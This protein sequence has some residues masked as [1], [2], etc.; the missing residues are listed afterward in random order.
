MRRA[1]TERA[2]LSSPEAET[3]PDARPPTLSG[4]PG[5]AHD[6]ASL[7][8]LALWLGVVAFGGGFAVAQRIKRTVVDQRRWLD[9]A[10]FV[11]IFSV[12]SALPGTTS[13]NVLTMVGLRL[14]GVRAALLVVA[15]F[16]APSIA[17][18]IVFGMTY[19]HVRSVSMVSSLLDG[20]SAATVGVI[21]A[22]AID[23]RAMALRGRLGWLLAVFA[24]VALA[25]RAL[26]LLEVV[27]LSGL[28][29]AFALR[30]KR[31]L[32]TAPPE[33]APT[34][35]DASTSKAADPVSGADDPFPPT[36]LRGIY[37]A[38]PA[39]TAAAMAAMVPALVLFVVFARIGVAT[40]GGGFA[41]VTPLE[42]EV[43]RARGWLTQ[44]EFHDAIVIGQVTPGPVAIAA[45]FIGYRVAALPGALAATVGIFG[46]PFVL[47]V[48]AGRSLGAFRKSRT[49]QGF[50]RGI[51]PAI[52]GVIFASAIALARTSLHRPLDAGIAVLATVAL[53]IRPKLSPLLPLAAGG[54]IATIAARL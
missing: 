40:F 14:G 31:A 4:L 12:A 30:P 3:R 41:M 25:T 17:L 13:T 44:A 22:V 1:D 50:L 38:A 18:M 37:L 49:V 42:D 5:G 27:L 21:A 36:S 53:V 23:M 43:V 35:P 28:V 47:A 16:L 52:V 39:F 32:R 7:V 33:L 6:L 20:M 2:P 19:T 54:L 48:I 8:L 34:A 26:N 46:P 10:T 51:A 29:G 45:T 11:E 24:T 15:S 9:S